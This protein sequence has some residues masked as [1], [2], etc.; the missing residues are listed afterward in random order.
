MTWNYSN[1]SLETS[2][3]A[4]ITSSATTMSLVSTAGLPVTYPFSLVVDYGLATAEVVTVTGLA[5]AALVVVRGQDGTAAQAHNAG[6]TVVH[7]VVARDLREPQTHMAASTDV[8]GV[9]AS[10]AV[11]GTATTQTLT[12]KTLAG[13]SNTITGLGNSSITD[14]AASKLTGNFNEVNA[15]ATADG[16][17]ALKATGTATATANVLEVYK[18]GTRQAYVGSAGDAYFNGTLGSFGNLSTQSHASISGNITVGGGVT[19]SGQITS[20]AYGTFNGDLGA[21]PNVRSIVPYANFGVLA[22]TNAAPTAII[23]GMS[24]QTVDLLQFQNNAGTNVATI[25]VGG[26][27]TAG[28]VSGTTINGTTDMQFGG[29]SLPRGLRYG[30]KKA[31][32]SYGTGLSTTETTVLTSASITLLANRLYMIYAAIP[33]FAN[34]GVTYGS[35]M[36]DVMVRVKRAGT[37]EAEKLQKLESATTVYRCETWLPF[38]TAT[39][40]TSAWTVTV[41][42]YLGTAATFDVQSYTNHPMCFMVFDQ[43]PTTNYT[44]AG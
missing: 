21:G 36:I 27:V 43:G 6:A 18:G 4:S 25:G 12:N 23:R 13:G 14:L 9:G 29:L 3:S 28:A 35:S 32:A 24:G 44:P 37:T 33:M 22:S 34:T 15:V 38:Y 42:R 5:G 26:T 39:D 8:H 19:A 41:Q 40:N 2:L 1:T 11:V 31:V 17:V 7:A 16:N 30:L 20:G 10:S